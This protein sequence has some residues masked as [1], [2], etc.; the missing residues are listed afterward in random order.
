MYFSFP[1]FARAQEPPARGRGER[2]ERPGALALGVQVLPHVLPGGSNARAN[3]GPP[4]GTG[5]PFV[6]PVG[7]PS[8]SAYGHKGR[9]TTVTHRDTPPGATAEFPSSRPILLPS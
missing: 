3:E 8:V 9:G 2:E 6:N 1:L 4:P 7:F 5:N